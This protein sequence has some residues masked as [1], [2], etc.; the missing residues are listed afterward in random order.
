MVESALIFLVFF[1]LIMGIFDFGQ[2]LFLQQALVEQA[3]YA[4]RWGAVNNPT[5]STSIQNMFLY[6]QS[7]SPPAGTPTY[8]GVPAADVNVSTADSGTDNYRLIV[9]VA[10]YTYQIYSFSIFGTYTGPPINMV[11]PLGKY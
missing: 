1:T 10:G 9:N 2:F 4:A 6:S 5:D 3:R 11:V 7:A 8:F